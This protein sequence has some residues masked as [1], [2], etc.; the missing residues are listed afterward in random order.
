M[1]DI[2]TRNAETQMLREAGEAPDRV[3]DQSRSSADVLEDV[4]RH[5]SGDRVDMVITCARGSSSHATVYGKCLIERLVGKPVAAFSP[6]AAS[7]Y[8][9]RLNLGRAVFLAVSQSG[10]SEDL[11]QS[12]E[13]AKAG[14]ALT[15]AMTNVAGNPLSALCDITIPLMAGEEQSVAATKSFICSLTAFA[16]LAFRAGKDFKGLDALDKLPEFMKQAWEGDDWS[17]AMPILTAARSL[18]VCGRGVGFGIAREA[19]LKLKETS[20]L[21]AEA[22]SAAELRHGP[23]AVVSGG[24]PILAFVAAD[25]SRQSV[26]DLVS[27]CSSKGAKCLAVGGDIPDAVSLGCPRGDDT[28]LTPVLQIQRFYRFAN[29]LSL[30]R[31]GNPDRPPFLK[32]VTVT[33]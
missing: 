28:R 13:A 12:A 33:V 29:G 32:K 2:S 11:L 19:A 24:F 15:V 30:A 17:A 22:F 3:A 21:H 25:A 16:G 26:H 14:G 10:R 20:R 5:L 1:Q 6:S 23:M 9:A 8:G 7:I 31:G 27:F 18:F 4:A